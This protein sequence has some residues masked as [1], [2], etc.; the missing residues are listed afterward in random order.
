MNRANGMRPPAAAI[1]ARMA[2]MRAGLPA[3][4]EVAGWEVEAGGE[5]SLIPRL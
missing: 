4:M 1:S 3:S 2:A 5:S